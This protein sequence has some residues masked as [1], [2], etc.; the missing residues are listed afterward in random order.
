MAKKPKV[1]PPLKGSHIAAPKVAEAIRQL[2]RTR[3]RQAILK[4]RSALLQKLIIEGG[5]G[6]AHGYRAY[7]SHF[8]GFHGYRYI[9]QRAK[10]TVKLVPLGEGK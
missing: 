6:S 4:Q 10:D 2:I 8:N 9:N 1:K 5:G 7:I 3:A